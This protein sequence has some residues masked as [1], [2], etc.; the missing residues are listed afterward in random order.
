VP[1]YDFECRECGERFEAQVAQA[2][3]PLCPACGASDPERLI[4]PF[5]GPFTTGLRGGAARRSD[6]TRRVREEQRRE[7]RAMKRDK[8]EQG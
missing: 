7:D 8:R 4:S 1:L 5:A 3:R 2:E 6:A